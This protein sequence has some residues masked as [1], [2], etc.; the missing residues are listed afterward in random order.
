MCVSITMET[1]QINKKEPKKVTCEM[2]QSSGKNTQFDTH[3][4][5]K[6][7]WKE[8]KEVQ[9]LGVGFSHPCEVYSL[10]LLGLTN[11]TM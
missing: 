7:S 9:M 1:P 2:N 3:W 6:N 11:Y 5:K 4:L 8:D 10:P